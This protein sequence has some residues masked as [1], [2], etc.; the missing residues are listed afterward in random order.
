[1]FYPEAKTLEDTVIL[2]RK[3]RDKV[4]LLISDFKPFIASVIQKRL[5]RYLEYGTDD[6][7]SIG[8]IAFNE[9]IHAYDKNKGKFLS[10]ARLV[11]TN[12]LIDY[13][14][15]QSKFKTISL[16]IDEDCDGPSIDIL[17][18]KAVQQYAFDDEIEDRK[19]EIIEYTK[20]LK[21][22]GISFTDLVK[23]SPRQE[24]LR[25]DYIKTAKLI[26][27]NLQLLNDLERSRRLPIKE[28]EKIIGLHRKKI[29][30]GRIYI[31]AMVVAIIN[32]FSFL[33]ISCKGRQN[34]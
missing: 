26:A 22:W 20:A 27:G 28:L 29:E 13:F 10:F 8:L 14:R 12:R 6:E 1:L 25:N 9:A 16:N 24:S 33:D 17:D 15:K 34:I 4:E 11:I 7:L 32:K 2:A 19:F 3:S 23:V 30:R 21:E 18:K 5:G 31:I